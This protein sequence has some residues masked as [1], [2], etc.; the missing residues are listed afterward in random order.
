[1]IEGLRQETF[2][3]IGNHQKNFP[4]CF[5]VHIVSPVA[6]KKIERF[7]E[8][9]QFMMIITIRV[10]SLKKELFLRQGKDDFPL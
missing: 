6:P 10:A 3:F 1:M 2:L 5:L 8:N 4:I 9:I 7:F